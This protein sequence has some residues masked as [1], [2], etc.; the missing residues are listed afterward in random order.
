M[1]CINGNYQLTNGLVLCCRLLWVRRWYSWWT[2]WDDIF[3]KGHLS[4]PLLAGPPNSRWQWGARWRQRRRPIKFNIVYLTT[5]PPPAERTPKLEHPESLQNTFIL[6]WQA[7][8]QDAHVIHI[9]TTTVVRTTPFTGAYFRAANT[10]FVAGDLLRAVAADYA[11]NET[12][13]T[14]NSPHVLNC[15][16]ERQHRRLSRPSENHLSSCQVVRNLWLKCNTVQRVTKEEI[17]K[18]DNSTH[19]QRKREI[20]KR[21]TNKIVSVIPKIYLLSWAAVNVVGAFN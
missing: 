15:K 20:K 11:V 2:T 3:I 8:P 5:P 7:Q 9:L 16:L 1:P 13:V 10:S 19:L 21:T 14:N 12:S 6:E 4:I 17:C 18:L